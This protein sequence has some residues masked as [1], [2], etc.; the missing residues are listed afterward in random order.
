MNVVVEIPLGGVNKYEYDEEMG[1]FLL[2]RTLY[3]A[4][5]YPFEYGFIPQTRAQDG[6]SID[7]VLMASHPTFPGCVV[8]SRPIGVMHMKDEAGK[9]DKILAVPI[10]SVNPRYENIKSV[11]D[12]AEHVRKEFEQF[13]LDYKRLEEKKNVRLLGWGGRDDALRVIEESIRRYKE[14]I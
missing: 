14:E 2:D 12:L 4:V 1:A 9:D 13:L 8:R 11:E 5:Y 7:V 6:D 10:K 3:S